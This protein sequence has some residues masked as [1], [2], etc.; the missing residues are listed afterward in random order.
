MLVNTYNGIEI[1]YIASAVPKKWTSLEET[2]NEDSNIIK[3]FIKKT[4]VEGRYNSIEQQ[5]T[6]DLC[7]Q[8]AKEILE[9][10]SK[11][12]EEIGILIFVTQTPDY[13]VPATA[14]VLQ[15]R[16]ELSN[17]CMAFDVNLGC[18][19]YSHGI[20]IACSLLKASNCKRALLLAGDTCAKIKS[21]GNTTELTHSGAML[22]GDAGTATL[23]SKEDIDEPI[24]VVPQTDGNGFKAIISPYG[25]FRHPVPPKGK[26]LASQMDDIAVFNFACEEVPSLI[27]ATMEYS[28]SK[29][30]NYDCLVLHQAN[31]FIMKRVAKLSGFAAD[32]MLISLD[33]FGNTSS[34]SLP[35]T[36]VKEYGESNKGQKLHALMCGFGVG[37][38]WSTVDCH[39]MDT[40]ILPLI[41]TDYFFD[42]GYMS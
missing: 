5:T 21:S 19:G 23:L 12:I 6:S 41:Y 11:F 30:E 37:L 13:R 39:I 28:G 14:C 26:N 4:G 22:F 9:K 15:K 35:I 3:K 42:D 8:A 1:T 36:L 20:S 27:K 29:A 33:K 7:Y 31:L 10:D 32:K 38:S 34:A 2:S 25:G 18:S 24:V 17:N 16:L 40:S